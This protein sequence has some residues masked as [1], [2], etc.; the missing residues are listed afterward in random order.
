MKRFL[1][2][3]LATLMALTGTAAVAEDGQIVRG[4]SITAGKVAV[5]SLDPTH[6]KASIDDRG[7][8]I[9]IYE[10]LI[11]VDDSGNLVPRLATSWTIE[12]DTTIVFKLR[13]DV[14]FHD[15]EKFNAQ[16]VKTAFDYY[17]SEACSPTWASYISKLETVDVVD[18]Y[19]VQ[20]N[21]SAPS[22]SFMSALADNSG[23]IVSPD[24]IENHAADLAIYAKGTG[25]F[26]VEK[27]VEG[28]T[29]TLARNP[30]Y[31]EAGQDNQ[32]LPYLDKVVIKIITDASVLA[33]NLRSGDIDI[34]DNV[35]INNLEVIAQDANIKTV[36]TAAKTCYM[37]FMNNLYEPLNNPKVRQAISYAID[38]QQICDATTSGYGIVAPFVVTPDQ[39]FYSEVGAYSLDVAKAKELLA[40]AG[41]P[42]GFSIDLTCISRDPDNI[43]VQ[44]LQAQL[45]QVGITAN[46]DT[47][48]RTA[49]VGM[50][51]AANTETGAVLGVAKGTMPRT[52]AYTQFN[53]FFSALSTDNFSRYYSDEFNVLIDKLETTYDIEARKAIC[54]DLQALLLGDAAAAALYQQPKFAA[55]RTTLHGI[56]YDF[57]G[58]YMFKN[59][60]TTK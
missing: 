29:L 57:A 35:S 45:A 11:T 17:K 1:I 22:A 5:F 13:E 30:N 9:Q 3:L 41:Y 44:I 16:A 24:A 42:N 55:E 48:E 20:F 28:D 7:V 34:A 33:T 51:N 37:L 54:E 58:V 38:R 23:M 26:M 25:P 47:M 2:L 15:G 21:L 43:I 60:Y 4:G 12:D 10:T 59:A 27:Y 19:T 52:D 50:M 39:W 31:Y 18:E 49:W 40:E 14:A 46:I 53:V 32:P 8:L 36:E 6:P 56:D